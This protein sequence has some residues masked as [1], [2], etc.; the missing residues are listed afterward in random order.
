MPPGPVGPLSPRAPLDLL[1]EFE[2]SYFASPT[3]EEQQVFNHAPVAHHDRDGIYL[4]AGPGISAG[5]GRH[6]NLLDVAPTILR[7][8]GI[9]SPAE[10]EG[11]SLH[12]FRGVRQKASEQ[13]RTRVTAPSHEGAF[14]EDL[15]GKLRA[16][17]Y[18]E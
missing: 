4:L 3:E 6:A 13:I 10:L 8:Y 11:T 9:G 16:L 18:L 2:A 15:R 1:V 14:D 12:A 17:G 7:F 5:S